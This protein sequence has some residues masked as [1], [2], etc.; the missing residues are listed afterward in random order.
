MKST[1]NAILLLCIMCFGLSF[2]AGAA[3]TELPSKEEISCPTIESL[4]Y[5]VVWFDIDGF[6]YHSTQSQMYWNWK[7]AAIRSGDNNWYDPAVYPAYNKTTHQIRVDYGWFLELY[8]AMPASVEQ[9]FE[10]LSPQGPLDHDLII[11]GE[12][13]CPG[14]FEMT[15]V[16]W[17]WVGDTGMVSMG[18]VTVFDQEGT[19]LPT[20]MEVT[21]TSTR[22]IIKRKGLSK[23]VFPII[24]DPVIGEPEPIAL[25]PATATLATALLPT[26]AFGTGPET[27]R[28][29]A[30]LSETALTAGH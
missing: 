17:N 20:E 4:P 24:I 22:I 14:S 21:P 16:G 27:S 25:P 2:K 13:D 9:K 28:L 12:I 23:A 29:G 10:I 6:T 26:G 18:P 3:D 8:D 15:P 7:L 19:I 5:Y 11:E 30:L 1:I